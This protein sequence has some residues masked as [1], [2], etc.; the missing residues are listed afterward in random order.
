[1]EY[2]HWAHCNAFWDCLFLWKNTWYAVDKRS[3]LRR[4]YNCEQL[5]NRE[6]A[7]EAL[8]CC[9]N[10][11]LTRNSVRWEIYRLLWFTQVTKMNMFRYTNGLC[12]RRKCSEHGSLRTDEADTTSLPTSAICIWYH[13]HF[14]IPRCQQVFDG[15]FLNMPTAYLSVRFKLLQS[16]FWNKISVL[17]LGHLYWLQTSA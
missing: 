17:I 2:L 15:N 1:M 12:G 5:S 13:W 14:R 16:N 10:G 3:Y 9:L 6:H 7:K 4:Q 8:R 11:Q